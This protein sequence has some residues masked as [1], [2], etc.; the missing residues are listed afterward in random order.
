[1]LRNPTAAYSAQGEPQP[2]LGFVFQDPTLMPWSN[3]LKN[4]ML[5]G[6]EVDGLMAS[7]ER[8]RITATALVPT[9][10]YLLLDHPRRSEFDLS[11]LQTMVYAGAPI[12]PERLGEALEHQVNGVALGSWESA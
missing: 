6:L 4:V 11:S 2:D 8:H 9:I 7:I 1:M 12:A 10:I 5:P 3:T